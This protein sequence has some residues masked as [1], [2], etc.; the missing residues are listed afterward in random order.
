MYNKY[1]FV[2]LKK[3]SIE[4]E[5]GGGVTTLLKDYIHSFNT[6]TK[7]SIFIIKFQYFG[8]L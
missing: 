8:I 2:S 1:F 3:K 4:I 6:N 7:S 5:G